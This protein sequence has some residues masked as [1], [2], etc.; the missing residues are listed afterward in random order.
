MNFWE[1]KHQDGGRPDLEHRQLAERIISAS[2]PMPDPKAHMLWLLGLQKEVLRERL[3]TIESQRTT[4]EYLAQNKKHSTA[5]PAML[6]SGNFGARSLDSA[7]E[8][9]RAVEQPQL[10]I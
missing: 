2:G 8:T 1:P 6:P 3:A 4:R 9:P 7:H 5:Q 10:A